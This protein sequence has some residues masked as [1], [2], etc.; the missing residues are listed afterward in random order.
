MT[1]RTLS[2]AF[3]VLLLAAP[4][5]PSEP[6]DI[7]VFFA[8]ASQDEAQSEQALAAIAGAWSDDYAAMIV[9]M[10]RFMRPKARGRGQADFGGLDADETEPGNE[11][12]GELGAA[13]GGNFPSG[14]G[15]GAAE[16]HPS[17]RVRERL[18]GFLEEQTGQRLGDDL[19]AWRRWYWNRP[20]S[21]HPDYTV[22]KAVL[23]GQIDERMVEFFPVDGPERI[24]L[25][26]VDWGGVRVNGIP[27]LDHPRTLSAGEAGYLK[28]S[29]VVFGVAVGGE[30]RAYPKRIL[31]WHELALDE[32]GGTELAVVYCTLCGTV[33][34]YG[35]EVA[36]RHFT[37]GTSGLLYRS[38]K[39][40]FDAETKSLWSTTE[41]R[42][43]IGALADSDLEL[44][45]YPVVTTTWGEWRR[46]HPETSV[47]SLDTGYQRDYS[48]GAAYRDYFRTD[49]LLFAVPGADDRL[50]NKDEVLALALPAL[51]GGA[52]EALAISEK[53]LRKKENRVFHARLGGR[54]LVVITSREGANRVYEAGDTRFEGL[55]ADGSVL[56]SSGGAWTLSEDALASAGGETRP[57]VAARRSF[58][59]GWHAQYPDTTLIR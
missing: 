42:P 46:L 49:T 24:R 59:F 3:G 6:P 28:D 33:I 31:G 19:Q 55:A 41:G 36:G 43:V 56:D 10:A 57:R 17:T 22:F 2:P 54:E 11:Y 13:T 32:L 18:V 29:N 20:Y 25:D 1:K 51:E 34:P 30:Y 21:P 47:L 52:P 26:E 40:M 12:L 38:N 16:E 23:Y 4:A 35:S 15:G 48:E 5:A 45:A 14:G 8:A 58:W 7:R 27:P 9:D 44:H 37:F 39:L 50:H 53:F